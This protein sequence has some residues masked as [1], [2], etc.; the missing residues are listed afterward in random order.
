VVEVEESTGRIHKLNSCY[1][2]FIMNETINRELNRG[3][4]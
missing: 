4:M 1:I 3:L 2:F